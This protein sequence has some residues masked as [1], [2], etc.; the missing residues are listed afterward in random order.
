MSGSLKRARPDKIGDKSQ[1]EAF[2]TTFQKEKEELNALKETRSR[3]VLF[4]AEKHAVAARTKKY[5]ELAFFEDKKMKKSI[6]SNT[7]NSFEI[8]AFEKLSSLFDQ[9]N[10]LRSAYNNYFFDLFIVQQ[11]NPLKL[12]GKK[13]KD[14]TLFQSRLM[15]YANVLLNKMR[16]ALKDIPEEVIAD[17]IKLYLYKEE[18]EGSKPTKVS[19]GIGDLK[20]IM[21][22]KG[23]ITSEDLLT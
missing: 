10:M 22:K 16:N 12:F 20:E 13:A 19:E 17:P 8:I 4:S 14:I 11:K 21:K 18:K 1:K 23:K 9:N 3:I 15:S 7:M 2:R 6:D 5:C